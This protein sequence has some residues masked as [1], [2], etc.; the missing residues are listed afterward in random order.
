MNL[1]NMLAIK[2]MQF[3]S[4]MAADGEGIDIEA[5][6]GWVKTLNSTLKQILVPILS[7]V[8]AAGAIYAVVIAIQM[9]KA[10]SGEKREEAK[11]RLISVIVAVVVLVVLIIFFLFFMPMILEAV[12][13]NQGVTVPEGWL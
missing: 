10:D 13:T 5:N 8:A 12:L 2:F 6:F 3:K 7:V 9:A 4:L 1:L 11:K